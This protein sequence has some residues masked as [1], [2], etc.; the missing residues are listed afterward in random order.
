MIPKVFSYGFFNSL[1][2]DK[3]QMIKINNIYYSYSDITFSGPQGSELVL[4]AFNIDICNMF[5]LDNIYDIASF[6]E[7]SA[8]YSSNVQACD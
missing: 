5:P 4:M 6:N 8:P 2:T 7:H 3:K 1:L